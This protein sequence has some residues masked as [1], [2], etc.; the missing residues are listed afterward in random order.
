MEHDGDP[1]SA[2]RVRVTYVRGGCA[3]RVQ[4]R[5]CVLACD[6]AM[7]PYLCREL[8][9]PQR[10]AL[11]FQV[12]TPMLYTTVALR[13]WRALRSQFGCDYQRLGD[14]KRKLLVRLG[15]V[16]Q[17]YPA[18]RVSDMAAGLLLHPSKTHIGR[19]R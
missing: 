10:E 8:P 6:N 5:S 11:A 12:K 17:V 14:F 3:Y 13:N 15:D 1:D 16:L 9:A 19:Q 18:A 2:K 4:A 7:I